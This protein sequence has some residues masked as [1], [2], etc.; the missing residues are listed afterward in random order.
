[1]RLGWLQT[2]KV[3][4]AQGLGDN[5]ELET[6]IVAIEIPKKIVGSLELHL[7]TNNC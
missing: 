2:W 5:R 6:T 7:L 3:K 4:G 1:M